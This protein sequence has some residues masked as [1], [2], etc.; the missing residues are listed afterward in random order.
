MTTAKIC[1]PVYNHRC[2]RQ[3]LFSK[4]WDVYPDFCGRVHDVK[5]AAGRLRSA[6][7]FLVGAD[8]EGA[9]I[10]LLIEFKLR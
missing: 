4:S 6:G 8:I 1:P 5:T 10:N 9:L 7:V 3:A 2:S